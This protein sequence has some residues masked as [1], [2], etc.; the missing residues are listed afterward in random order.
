M[1]SKWFHLKSWTE[2]EKIRT[3][4]KVWDLI[5]NSSL[6][7]FKVQFRDIIFHNK[8]ADYADKFR[9]RLVIGEG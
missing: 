4:I 5:S 2:K 1:M 7:E 6:I 9:V 8:A 3:W